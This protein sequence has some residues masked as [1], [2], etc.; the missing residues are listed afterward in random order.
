MG[1]G[2]TEVVTYAL[3]SPRHIETFAMKRPVPS[4]GDEPQPAPTP[5]VVTNPLSRDHSVLRQGL[6]GSLLDV[7]SGN[8]RRDRHDVAVF[9]V[10][11]GYGRAG[12]VAQEWWRLGIALVGDCLF[13]GSIGR[14]DLPGGSSEQLMDS[15]LNKIVPLG[16]DVEVHSGHGPVTTIGHERLT[17]PFLTGA[18]TLG[19]GF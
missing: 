8:L 3:V 5:I 14:T 1:A 7:V 19:R 9:E 10:G 15:L 6:A 12:E 2:L 18:Y 16:D 4:I 13:A 11:K 17:N